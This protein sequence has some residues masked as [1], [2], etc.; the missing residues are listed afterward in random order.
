MRSLIADGHDITVLTRSARHTAAGRNVSFLRWNGREMP[1]GMG[2]FDVVINLAGTSIADA[3]WTEE[4]KSLIR[5]SRI[6]ATQACVQYINKSSRPPK[7]FISASAVGFF[8]GDRPELVDETAEAG[9]DFLAEVCAAWE[10]T[11]KLAKIRTVIPRFGVVLGRD[12]GAFPLMEAAYKLFL[13]GNFAG[14]RQGFPWVHVEDVVGAI[15]FAMDNETL[16]GPINVAAPETLTQSEFSAALAKAV[17]R[18]AFMPVPKFA[19]NWVFGERSVLF[20]GGQK[21]KPAALLQAGYTFKYDKVADALP[22]LV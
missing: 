2:F 16:S 11:A 5:T 9:T 20:W 18:P 14:G 4:Y 12:G 21:V 22:T 19:L 17:S 8:G 10:N 3:K 1:L 6:E 13:G 7:V 15:R